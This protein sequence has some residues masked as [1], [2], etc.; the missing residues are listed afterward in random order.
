[1]RSIREVH[2]IDQT[3]S[4]KAPA[5]ARVSS[6]RV[7]ACMCNDSTWTLERSRYHDWRVLNRSNLRRTC[8]TVC[9]HWPHANMWLTDNAV[10]DIATG[11]PDFSDDSVAA[12]VGLLVLSWPLVTIM[13]GP[14]DNAVRPTIMRLINICR[15]FGCHYVFE[16][17]SLSWFAIHCVMRESAYSNRTSYDRV[18]T[19][20]EKSLGTGKSVIYRSGH[21]T[22]FLGMRR[23]WAREIFEIRYKTCWYF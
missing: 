13:A 11:L 4:L 20:L 18:A 12:C 3:S 19:F 17:I 6:G 5:F 22:E 1:M 21:G 7:R 23:K 8:H 16:Q 2:E 10:L 14:R 15:T 9:Q